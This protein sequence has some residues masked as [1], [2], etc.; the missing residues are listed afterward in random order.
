MRT[1]ILAACL[2]VVM[3][4][5]ALASP[6]APNPIPG[7]SVDLSPYPDYYGG[8]TIEIPPGDVEEL[9]VHLTVLENSTAPANTTG[10]AVAFPPSTHSRIVHGPGATATWD[11]AIG[12]GF[13]M[14]PSIWYPFGTVTIHGEPSTTIA[15][16]VDLDFGTGPIWSN[17]IQKHITPE[18]SSLLAL[19]TGVF[20]IGGIL[21]RRRRS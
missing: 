11:V 10:Y 19:G 16:A 14:E 15:I 4:A 7:L 21:L 20:G 1:S 6:T 3:L 17:E 5:P 2:A 8:E 18:P 12:P 13:Y 9:W